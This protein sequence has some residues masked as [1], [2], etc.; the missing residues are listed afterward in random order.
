MTSVNTMIEQMDGLQGTQDLS[1][2]ESNFVKDIV[3][4]Y[5]QNNKRTDFFTEKVVM[6]IEKIWNKHFS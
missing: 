2:W 3:S 6:C 4:R 1:A 5:K